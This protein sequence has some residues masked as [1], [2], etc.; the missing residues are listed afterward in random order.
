M[1]WSQNDD[2]QTVLEEKQHHTRFAVI[3]VK[4]ARNFSSIILASEFMT[5]DTLDND[6]EVNIYY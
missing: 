3:K 6:D 2:A 4:N 1:P 5:F